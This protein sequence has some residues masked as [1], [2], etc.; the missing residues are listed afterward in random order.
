MQDIVR[1]A[2]YAAP[3]PALDALHAFDP[4]SFVAISIIA[5]A[6]VYIDLDGSLAPSLALSWE[7]DT[8]LSV[9]F[10]LRRDVTFHDGTPMTAD[11]VVATFGEH[12]HPD[13]PTINGKGI[14]SALKSVEK[15]DTYKVRFET[16]FP[17]AMLLHRFFFS[18]IYPAHVLAEKGRQ[19]I[20]E[21]PIGTGGY[22]LEEW[23]PGERILLK[24][25]D[26]H[27]A[28]TATVEYLEIPIVPQTEWV[29]A[30][31]N[32]ELDIALNIDA[33]DAR[34]ALEAGLVV[35]HTPSTLSHFFLL[36]K[37]GPLADTRV[38]QALNHAIHRD[39]IVDVAEH[40]NGSPAASLLGPQQYGH[41]ETL[42]PYRY[43]VDKAKQLLAE[44]GYP[45]G[46]K[47]SGLVSSTSA[48]VFLAAKEFLSRIGVELDAEV[49]PRSEW[50]RRVVVARMMGGDAFEGDFAVTNCDNPTINGIFHHFIFLFSQG[51][52][53]IAAHEEY[54]KRFLETATNLDP[55]A[56]LEAINALERYAQD[57]ALALF[58]VN[59]HVYAAC[60]P[61]LHI[62][63]PVS[64]HFDNS[65]FWKLTKN[66]SV[67]PSTGYTP[68][69]SELA[70]VGRLL[71][72]TSHPSIYFGPD[73]NTYEDPALRRLW[74]R[75]RASQSRWSAQD[76]PMMRELVS[77]AE[78][79]L[80]LA[81]VLDTTNRVAIVGYND[82]G[83]RLFVNEGYR[84]MIDPEG[85]PLDE[86][87]VASRDVESWQEIRDEV[88]ESGTWS[89]AVTVT[90]GDS[91]SRLHL[92]ATRAR[93]RHGAA[94]GYTYVFSDFSG[95]EERVKSQALRRLMEHVPYGLFTIG[96]NLEVAPGYSTA[97]EQLFECG[98][99]EIEGTPL[100]KLLELDTRTAEN[101]GFLV[102]QI[103]MD[104]LPEEVSVDQLP[105]RVTFREKVLSL[106]ASVIRDD[107]GQIEGVLFSALDVTALEAAEREV[108]ETRAAIAVLEDR[109]RFESVA[110]SYLD[111]LE[112][113]VPH[114]G[115]DAGQDEARRELHT[116]KGEFG[117]FGQKE[118]VD[119]IHAAEDAS[120]ISASQ[121]VAL[122]DA[123][124]TRLQANE[125]I[126]QIRRGQ[127]ADLHIE[128][129]ALTR[130]VQT[131]GD[132]GDARATKKAVLEFAAYAMGKPASA[133]AGP[134]AETTTRLGTRLGKSVKFEFEGADVRVPEAHTE[135]YRVL[136]HLLRNA[137]DHG[138]EA[139][140]HRGDKP[141]TGT[142]TF[143]VRQ[144][145]DGFELRFSDD[146]RGINADA[147][148][149]KALQ[150]GAITQDA[151]DGLKTEDERLQLIF[152]S[153]VSTAEET[154]DL[155]GRG[156]G[157]AAVRAVVESLGGT[158][159]LAST[160]GQ[161]M[162]LTMRVPPM[163]LDAVLK[164]TLV[165]A[166]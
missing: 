160:P 2:L 90:R 93:D 111:A 137:I 83:R 29:D 165:T 41:D 24:R 120:K 138:L 144:D 63:L 150:S 16:H 125:H 35:D 143:S 139:P 46:F 158:V 118:V 77:S 3:P 86:L 56:G 53:S 60:R 131:V 117:M 62:P 72:A 70:D 109:D 100:P 69:S 13:N 129:S 123:F 17:D 91:A 54:D 130:L 104:I 89:G 47:L 128:P 4:E 8:P 92:T 145:E 81:T 164:H 127:R 115:N 161:G 5:D 124:A 126:W 98:G 44:A 6:L 48:G 106:T 151:L 20:L 147:V 76:A 59:A 61:G 18:Q 49:V 15:L 7:R 68:V 136:P 21:H 96:E 153:G 121:L 22:Q 97:C 141:T 146:G 79:K 50:M 28:K 119:A 12:L 155:S 66:A 88:C 82:A 42:P 64:G 11:D 163:S 37:N 78:S 31:A 133:M 112:R 52:F 36:S 43:S 27:W 10:D 142:I 80:H 32:D 51:P 135:L 156:V 45:D 134:L 75:L 140:E 159:A 149:A 85:V 148:A 157:M 110:L 33:P 103:F 102:E 55:T 25:F 95:A 107:A 58:T 94:M 30:L 114:V 84:A 65:A 14:F 101:L 73:R 39:L 34:R 113:L 152:L 57:E 71:E 19:A 87:G 108:E 132:G 162:T 116:F 99:Q 23:V 122:R 67:E 26:G 154:T 166:A 74:D 105:Q 1:L 38:R 40:G 9:V